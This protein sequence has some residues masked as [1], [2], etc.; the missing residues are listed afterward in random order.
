MTTR[1][2]LDR[3]AVAGGPSP[4]KISLSSKGRTVYLPTGIR[5]IPE[6]WDD[7]GQRI[8]GHPQKG[9]PSGNSMST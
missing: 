3:R 6:Q 2:Y 5:I 9:R 4:V 1:L 8:V 7:R